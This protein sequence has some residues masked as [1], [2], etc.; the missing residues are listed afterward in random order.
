MIKGQENL[1]PAK[2]GEIRNK[3]GKKKGTKNFKTILEKFLKI[4]TELKNPLTNEIKKMSIQEA[5]ILS[6]L[7]KAINKKDTKAIELIIERMDGKLKET[8]DLTTKDEQLDN[9]DYS[10]LSEREAK[11]MF[12]GASKEFT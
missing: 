6:L 10:K 3:Y 2:K 11:K 7:D 8:V 9:I 12:K 5:V 4:K 1:I